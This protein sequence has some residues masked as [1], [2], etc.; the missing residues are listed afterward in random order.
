MYL[1]QE[2][3]PRVDNNRNKKQNIQLRY[4]GKKI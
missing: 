4:Q 1:K 2:D 3:M